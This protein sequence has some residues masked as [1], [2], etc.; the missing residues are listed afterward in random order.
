MSKEKAII[1]HGGIVRYYLAV[2]EVSGAV[3]GTDKNPSFDSMKLYYNPNGYVHIEQTDPNRYNDTLYTRELLCVRMKE[4]R[5][6]LKAE[7]MI[8]LNEAVSE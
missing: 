5:E 4:I 7:Y 1:D 6:L 2:G 8:S 3:L